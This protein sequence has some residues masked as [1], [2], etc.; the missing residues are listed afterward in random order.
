RQVKTQLPLTFTID[1]RF[2]PDDNGYSAER[3]ELRAFAWGETLNEAID[4]LL[5]V[6]ILTAETLVDDHKKFSDLRDPRLMHA[7]F[8]A[9]LG[10]EEKIRKVLGL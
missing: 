6:L 2:H 9:T 1:F 3:S 5:D 7:Q 10:D 4:N 8:I